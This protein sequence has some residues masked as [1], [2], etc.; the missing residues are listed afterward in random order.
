MT[1]DTPPAFPRLFSGYRSG[2]LDLSSRLVMLPH[3]TAMVRDGMPTEDD[4]AYYAV[5]TKG[6]GLVITG[7]TVATRS[8]AFR[9]RILSEGYNP[10]AV[11][12]MRKRC[13]VVH[14]NGARIVGQLCHLGREMT[15]M[16]SEY[17]P[18]SASAVRSPRDPYPPHAME[19]CEILAFIDEFVD[20]TLNLKASGHD[21]VELHAAHGYLFSQ[22]MSPA[23]NQRTD[24]WGGSLE[25]RLRLTTETIARVRDACGPGFIIGVRL[26]ADEETA[27]G[28]GVRDNVAITQLL[29]RQDE[30]DYLSITVGMRGAYVKDATQPIAP[31]ARAAGIIRRESGLP[32][33]VGNKIQTPE[34]AEK[35]LEDG[36]ADLIGMAR[37]FV[38]D[39]DFAKKAMAGRSNRIRPCVGLNQECRAFSPHLHC[40]LN[41]E[42]GRETRPL[43]ASVQA[44]PTAK[45]IAII[46]GGPAGMEAG[47]VAAARGHAVTLFEATEALGG[48]FLLAASLPNRNGLLKMVDH[49]LEELRHSTVTVQL[50]TRIADLST[51]EGEFDEVIVATGAVPGTLGQFAGSVPVLAWSDVLRDG[52]PTPTG[53]SHAVF[54]D[55]GTGFWFSYGVAEMLV[56]AGWRVTFLTSSAAIGANLPVES[57]APMLGRLGAGG[58]SFRVLTGLDETGD[59]GVTTVNLTSGEEEWLSCDLVVV[60]TARV[61]A[62]PPKAG[63]LPVHMIGDCITPRRITHALFE[64]QRL[65]RTI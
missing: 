37:A 55:E 27:D 61:V 7:A 41:P 19:E 60:Q 43:F 42:T 6:L 59:G 50:N 52:A 1:Q 49:L 15:G 28:L 40:S 64:G 21:G 45:R 17:F 25:S 4:V 29:A 11:E 12:I 44:T 53:G 36:V 2:R 24:G 38:A 13:D 54:V 8:A 39:P 47:R 62:P 33:I 34:L 48:Q 31:A 18:M 46:G 9:A 51:L 14:A 58:T 26:S 56:S 65:A 32:V 22:F 16:E 10:D 57:V 30:T 63:A 35:L 5:R 20:A 23:T 3:G